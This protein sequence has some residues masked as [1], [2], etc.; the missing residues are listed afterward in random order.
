MNLNVLDT[1]NSSIL[2]LWE[3]IVREKYDEDMRKKNI[4]MEKYR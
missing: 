4:E 1:L 2:L 3:I